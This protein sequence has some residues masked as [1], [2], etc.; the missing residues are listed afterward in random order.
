M[1]TYEAVHPRVFISYSHDSDAHRRRVLTFSERLR[2][3]GIN[4]WVDWYDPSPAEGWPRRMEKQIREADFVL[5]VCTEIYCRRVTGQ[6]KP[7]SGRGVCWEANLVYNEL[8]INKINMEKYL[9]VIFENN[10]QAHIP[11]VLQGFTPYHIDEEAGYEALYRR[12][13]NQPL[14]VKREMGSRKTLPPL[15]GFTIIVPSPA[16]E[17]PSTIDNSNETEN[18]D[19]FHHDDPYYIFRPAD[20]AVRDLAS[21]TCVTLVIKAPKQMGKSSLLTNFLYHCQQQ[22]KIYARIDFSNFSEDDYVDY[23]TFLSLIALI[24]KR[25]LGYDTQSRPVIDTQFS[26]NEFVEDTILRPSSGRLVIAFDEVDQVVGRYYQKDFFKML[27]SWHNKRN[28]LTPQWQ[29]L[30]IALVISTEPYLLIDDDYCSPF[31]VTKPIVLGPLTKEHCL[32]LNR[33]YSD[34]LSK[35][36]TEQLWDLLGGQ[37]F[38]VRSAFEQLTAPDKLGF[39]DLLDTAA[40]QHGPF[41]DHLRRLLKKLH[42]APE[43]LNAMQQVIRSGALSD[44]SLYDRLHSAGL[45]RRENNR[46]KPANLLYSRYFGQAI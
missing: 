2:A 32:E 37:P 22:Q 17:P 33:R 10:D 42:K 3:D 38:L 8:Y 36:E 20:K 45:V 39:Q 34:T 26:M 13:T 25:E 19:T 21:E 6:E 28:P 40:E 11:P 18:D 24:L 15:P 23:P 1:T 31:N 4:S 44:R 27:R 46:I 14:V 7:E 29:K 9:L 43:L 5:L 41:D 35:N 12:L 16:T 30:D